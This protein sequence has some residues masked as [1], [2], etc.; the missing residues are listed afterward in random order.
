MD[1][2]LVDELGASVRPGIITLLEELKAES[3][4]L[5]LWTSSTRERAKTILHSHKIHSYFSDFLFRED[6][7]PKNIGKNKDIRKVGG[8]ILVDDDPKEIAF[9]QSLGLKGVLVSAYR[10]SSKPPESDLQRIREAVYE[11]GRSFWG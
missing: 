5:K 8:S 3:H 6:Y 11:K 2:T 7:D 10:K 1:N 9:V 4:I